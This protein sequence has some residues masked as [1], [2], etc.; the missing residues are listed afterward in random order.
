[1]EEPNVERLLEDMARHKEIDL[2]TD[3]RR[4]VVHASQE[5]LLPSRRMNCSGA[6]VFACSCCS[7]WFLLPS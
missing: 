5:N 4:W 2:S 1:M 6:C 3:P 7:A